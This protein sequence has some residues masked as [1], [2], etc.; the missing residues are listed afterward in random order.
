[1]EGVAYLIVVCTAFK[2][3]VDVVITNTGRVD[4]DGLN[5]V[6]ES[7]FTIVRT[8]LSTWTLLLSLVVVTKLQA[9]QGCIPNAKPI[10]D[11]SAIVQVCGGESN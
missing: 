6:T 11:Y 8:A 4:G 1:M 9:D 10:L 2:N 7:D 5:P 3:L